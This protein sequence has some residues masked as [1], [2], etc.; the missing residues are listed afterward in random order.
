[1][2]FYSKI[3]ILKNPKFGIDLDGSSYCVLPFPPKFL[4]LPVGLMKYKTLSQ[5]FV[6]VQRGPE[7]I[8][9]PR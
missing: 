2:G 8:K 3:M 1:M 5:K 6:V 9:L 4:L 7:A